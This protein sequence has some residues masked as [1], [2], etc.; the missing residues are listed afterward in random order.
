MFSNSIFSNLRILIKIEYFNKRI[1]EKAK[2]YNSTIYEN[3][4]G[5]L[6]KKD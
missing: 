2:M 4:N 5:E 3:I 1:Y 6:I